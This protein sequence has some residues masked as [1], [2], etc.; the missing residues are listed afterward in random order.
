MKL[1]YFVK[2]NK[3]IYKIYFYIFT[4]VMKLFQLIIRPDKDSIIFV[5]YGGKKYDDSPKVIYEY[6]KNN[7]K[8]S[9]YKLYYALINPEKYNNIPNNEKVKIDSIK[10]YYRLFKCKYWITNSSVQRGL[11][12]KNEKHVNVLFMHGLTALKKSQKNI[13]SSG[14]QFKMVKPEKFDM[15]FIEGTKERNLVLN[16]VNVNKENLF[17]FGLPRIDELI[18]IN[19]NSTIKKEIRKKIGIPENK[20]VILYAPTYREYSKT[21][22]NGIT[23]KPSINIEKWKK[24]LKDEYVLLLTSHY[25]ISN[26]LKYNFDNK[27]VFD[28]SNYN[29]FN[30]LL[31]ISDI[32]ISDYSNIVFDNY[33]IEKPAFCFGYDYEEYI[34][35]GRGFYTKLE[36]IYL[37]GIIR[38]EISLINKIK[39]INYKKYKNYSISKR[40]EFILN[41]GD[42][43]EKCIKQIFSK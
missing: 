4:I 18:K 42:S 38:D 40:D 2:N 30:E 23:I 25:E 41:Y 13:N 43:T 34:S 26:E 20:K 5:S 28:V 11:N 27:F 10:Y 3:I 8:Y 15:V 12:F 14:E 16:N 6:L 29:S 21:L 9:N 36:D 1:K 39:I 33:I 37:D 24:E 7:E 35:K 17:N 19:S 32:L 22:V 31:S